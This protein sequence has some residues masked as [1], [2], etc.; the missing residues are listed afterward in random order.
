MAH[1]A[2]ARTL[3]VL[4]LGGLVGSLFPAANAADTP[5]GRLQAAQRLFELPSYR[6]LATRQIYTALKFLPAEEYRRAADALNNP[7]V[8]QALQGVIARSMAQTFSLAEL[9]HIERF[10]A[11]DEAR[12]MVSKIEGFEAVVIRELLAAAMT[13]PELA[14]SLLPK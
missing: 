12:S 10:L 2:A 3:I 8:V 5:E 4:L 6:Q 9:G 13:D 14:K 11:A 7:A 1:Q